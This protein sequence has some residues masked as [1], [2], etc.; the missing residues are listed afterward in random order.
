MK[1][2]LFIILLCAVYLATSCSSGTKSESATSIA[3]VVAAQGKN[4]KSKPDNGTRYLSMPSG[5]TWAF[6]YGVTGDG[7]DPIDIAWFAEGGTNGRT[8]YELQ[9]QEGG[10]YYLY[11]AGPKSEGQEPDVIIK[12]YAGADSILVTQGGNER[13]FKT[14]AS[15][16]TAISALDPTY[17]PARY[18]IKAGDNG[19]RW[20]TLESGEVTYLFPSDICARHQWVKDGDKYYYVDESGCRMLN[21]YAF[22]G[23]YVGRD[24]SWDNTVKCIDVNEMPLNGKP[25]V[26]DSEWTWSFELSNDNG[27]IQGQAKFSYANGRVEIYSVSSYGHSA[28]ALTNEDDEFVRYH[29]VVLDSGKTLRVSGAG[30]TDTYQLK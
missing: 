11:E 29:A 24:G 15:F 9:P 17:T 13:V 28:Y 22:D 27:E 7:Q 20:E 25:Y 2:N 3:D 18:A 14:A 8:I 23:F 12:V 6:E 30:V 26:N 16:D 1:H 10:T 4:N 19:G 21:N 5:D